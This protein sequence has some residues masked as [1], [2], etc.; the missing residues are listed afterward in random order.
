MIWRSKHLPA[1]WRKGRVVNPFEA[2]DAT[3]CGNDRPIAL[4]QILDKL[5]ISILTTG[6]MQHV[7]L[8][9]H[10]YAIRKKCGTHQP[11]FT[12]LALMLY[13]LTSRG[14]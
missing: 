1:G 12:D 7:S 6:L 2:G 13:S 8:H 14:V 3:L 11:L 5:S 9:D 4:L 10:Q